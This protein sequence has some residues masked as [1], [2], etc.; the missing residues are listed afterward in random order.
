MCN[1]NISKL[2]LSSEDIQLTYLPKP[3]KVIAYY[4]LNDLSLIKCIYTSCFYPYS[5]SRPHFHFP[6]WAMLV[7]SISILIL[8]FL[9]NL[10]K[11]F[12]YE[13]QVK[14]QEAKFLLMENLL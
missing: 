2:L 3:T 6:R 12:E 5:I 10:N 14:L 13:S 4:H 9:G 7:I 1:M 11:F 8:S